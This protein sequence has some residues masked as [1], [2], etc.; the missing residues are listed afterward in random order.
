MESASPALKIEMKGISKA[1]SG[2]EVLKA[3][4][5][6]LK[7]G[8]FHA[9]VGENGA[10]KSTLLKILC[11]AYSLDQGEIY[12][13]G[14]NVLIDSPAKAQQLGI[15]IVHQDINLVPYLSI[16]ENLFLGQKFTKK[17]L[18]MMDWKNLHRKSKEICH[19]VGLK[20]KVTTE[21]RELTFFEK[22]LLTI[23]QALLNPN[24]Q[25]MILD[26]PTASMDKYAKDQLFRVLTNL[27]ENKISVIYV[28]HRLNEVFE[29]TDRITVLRNG[30]KIK[31]V[32]TA[33]TSTDQLVSMMIGQKLREQYP[34]RKP[35]IGTAIL[36][37]KSLSNSV[38]G[39]VSFTL[40][41]GEIFGI[42][43]TTGSGKTELIR[44]IYGVDSYEQGEI[45]LEDRVIKSINP[46]KAIKKGI[47]LVP[48]D[49]REQGLILNMALKEN[50][51]LAN[52]DKHTR[53][54]LINHKIESKEA[55]G[56]IKRLN[57]KTAGIKQ[58]VVYLS[59]GN[60]QKVVL[61]KG[62]YTDS[63]LYLFDE[64]TKGVDVGA[65]AEI[66]KLMDQLAA[67]GTGI[68]L[69]TSELNEAIGLCD[70]IGVLYHGE[71]IAIVPNDQSN[72]TEEK[73]LALALA[74]ENIA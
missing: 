15:S 12:L 6:E 50:L 47:F 52:F 68:I 48:E 21:V 55:K 56:L 3:I 24:M 18:G 23:G 74:G 10:G 19:M 44:S 27:K 61:G 58:K 26:E 59:G 73:I 13:N 32:Q 5:F 53:S 69:A 34:D 67:Q 51:L 17:M 72:Q 7:E 31:T 2:T 38:L 66:Y 43:G 36:Q 35:N 33:E 16:A 30:E 40:H 1:F 57:I 42:F 45:I 8:E 9:L 39:N 46:K 25:V 11:G 62:L 63:K 4:D 65:K 70:R 14:Q 54:Y 49:R 60:Q 37:I 41:Q 28:S 22:R 20:R 64:P 71:L 29:I